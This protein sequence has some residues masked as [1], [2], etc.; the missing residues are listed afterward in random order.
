MCVCVCLST[1]ASVHVC[2]CPS[3]AAVALCNQKAVM[4]SE[5]HVKSEVIPPS[6]EVTSDSVCH[7]SYSLEGL[8]GVQE[9]LR[10]PITKGPRILEPSRVPRHDSDDRGS[11]VSL[12]EEQEEGLGEHSRRHDPVS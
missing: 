1:G 2:V 11:M 9:E 10:G 4:K 12:T 5:A 7:Y 8:S 6:F 3:D